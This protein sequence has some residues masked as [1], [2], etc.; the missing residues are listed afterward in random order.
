MQLD[1]FG[2]LKGM[3]FSVEDVVVQGYAFL[4]NKS[5]VQVLQSFGEEEAIKQVIS[6]SNVIKCSSLFILEQ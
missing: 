6:Y 5:K 2:K 3:R 1:G 4:V